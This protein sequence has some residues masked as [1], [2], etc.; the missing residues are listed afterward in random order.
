M[1]NPILNG[2]KFK[3]KIIKPKERDAIAELALNWQKQDKIEIEKVEEVQ[4]S[5]VHMPK[6][7]LEMQLR[8]CIC[9][10]NI[11]D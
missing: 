8:S 10:S 2:F 1:G 9:I 3:R 4:I 5:K 6:E 7:D 11:R